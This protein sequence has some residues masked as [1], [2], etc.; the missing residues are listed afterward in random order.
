MEE[1][2]LGLGSVIATGVGLVVASSCLLS[3]G[4]GSSAIGVTFII[5]MAIACILNIV[6]LLSIAELNALMPDLTGGLAQYSLASIGPFITIIC[7]VG[8]YA[9][10]NTIAGSVEGAMFGNT[11]AALIPGS[12]IPSWIYCVILVIVLMIANLNGVDVFIKVQ[13]FVAYA[14][15]ISLII[16]GVF[17]A[18][19]I[20]VGEIVEQPAVLAS[21]FSNVT[22]LCGLAFFLFIGGEYVVP[23]TNEVK[24]AKRNI[25]LGMIL[26]MIIIFCMQTF[27]TLGFKN[28]TE[29]G[30]LGA[31]T[32]PHVLYGQLLLGPIGKY[33][34]VIASLLAVISSVNTIMASLS[35][36]LM[37]MSKIEL[38]PDFFQ[39]KN[40][41]GA[42]YVGIIIQSLAFCIINITGLSTTD[43]LSFLISVLALLWMLSYI[44]SN[45]NVLL[46]RK[47]LP[48][49][50]RTFKVPFGPVI[51]IIGIVGTA[52]MIYN[53][54]PNWAI[55]LELYKVC[56]IMILLLT[57]YAFFWV[58]FKV[59]RPLFKPYPVKEVMAM[60][61]ERYQKFHKSI[62]KD[63][64][65][66]VAEEESY[67]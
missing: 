37:G 39:K 64:M 33:W 8:G 3:I 53:I 5:S 26:S 62:N 55:K 1:K 65:F 40:K 15:I 63:H 2:K 18:L 12:P 59:K 23:L 17:G 45:L 50:P 21:D 27:L 9:L 29:W 25:P 36:I 49:A 20:G 16:M 35:Y 41:K 7:M 34:M 67:E 19:G 66:Y 38:L 52:W 28:Y 31:S 13:N 58:K 54:D 57:I 10:C 11:I 4:I 42:P 24:N 56:G 47:R 61:N 43:S 46:L 44:V 48:N 60:E 51:P 14:L 30:E 32:T 6:T 22:G